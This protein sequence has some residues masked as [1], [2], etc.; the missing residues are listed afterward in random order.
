MSK[1]GLTS[2]IAEI[3]RGLPFNEYFRECYPRHYKG[4]LSHSPSREDKNPS[5]QV[6]KD[7]GYDHGGDTHENG[8]K[9]WDVILLH[10]TR[11]G[12]DFKTAVMQLAERCGISIPEKGQQQRKIIATY[13]Y[14]DE[15]GKLLYEVV[16]YRPKDFRQRRPDPDK[17]GSWIWSLKDTRRVL[18][19]LPQILESESIWL[20][21]GEKDADA[22]SELGFCGTTAPQGAGKWAKLCEDWKIQEPL[23]GKHVAVIP[24]NDAPGRDHAKEVAES[25]RGVAASVKV[26]Y[27]PG[28]AE[29]QDVS[30]FIQIHGENAREKLLEILQAT[31]EYRAELTGIELI[32]CK[33]L[34]EME[35][36]ELIW[37]VYNLIAQGFGFLVGKPKS[38]KSLLVLAI[39]LAV[40]LGRRALDHFTTH[41]GTVLYLALED[42]RRRMRSR[43]Q[44]MLNGL[45]PPENLLIACGWKSFDKG[46]VTDLQRFLELHPAT[47]LVIIDTWAKF[48]GRKGRS[49]DVYNSEYSD[50]GEL[51]SL[52]NL[53]Q[54]TILL[55]HHSRKEASDDPLDSI[56]GSTALSGAADFVLIMQ[57]KTRTEMDAVLHVTGRD[58]PDAQYALQFNRE[59]GQWLYLGSPGDLISTAERRQIREVLHQAGKPLGPSE[60]AQKCGKAKSTVHQTLGKMLDAGDVERSVQR[61][62]YLLPPEDELYGHSTQGSD[63][64]QDAFLDHP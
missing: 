57:R 22:L 59:E 5:F 53:Y 47:N 34:L 27:L 2:V 23:R 35:M 26:L 32:S 20:C 43:L 12:V 50:L 29:K 4:K 21:E 19:H 14:Q 58:V 36:P 51:Q 52:A 10:Q 62:K 41:Q 49:D 64:E 37:V 45:A 38:G 25:L 54:T 42:N 48:R 31:P 9:R 24:D 44:L 13:P 39:A 40:A 17:P 6:E 46:G 16:R 7:H 1:N 18:Y 56:L 61:G 33:A 60:I 55:V 11:Y 30:D 3:K 8:S 15:S 28:L 63:Y